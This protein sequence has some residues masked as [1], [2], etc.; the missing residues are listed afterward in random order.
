MPRLLI[1][2]KQADEYR[3]LIE[4]ANL[5]GLE[6]VSSSSVSSAISSGADCEVAFGE[7]ILLREVIPALTNLRWVQSTW[8]GVEPLLDP[9][10]RRNYTL[11]NARGVFGRLVSEYVFGYLLM[12]ER[13][14]FER[15][16]AQL[17]RR[18]DATVTGTLREKVIG[19]LGVGSIGSYL[20]G[21]A[22][23]FDMSVCGYTRANESCLEVD[24]YFHGN[25]RLEFARDLDYMVNVLPNTA[26][27]HHLVDA[28]LLNALPAHAFFINVGRGSA[29]DDSALIA[30]LERKKI[31]GAVLDVFEQEPL[32]KEHPFWT[33]PN[34][35]MTFH[36]AAPSFPV[37]ISKVFI[38]NY[39]YFIN[40]QELKY[41]VD[42]ERGY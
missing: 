22:K 30:A 26:E 1:V 38:E 32:P 24:T 29:V 12:F 17:D 25:T 31:A 35:W 41:Q 36:T 27:T 42:F 20:A 11:T 2:S 8:A 34:L 21:T 10:L 19:L 39:H 13:K 37:D 7:P 40:G 4:S 33:T 23:H 9:S 14:I 28:T 16:H 6:L 3:N 18:W 5:P 15:R